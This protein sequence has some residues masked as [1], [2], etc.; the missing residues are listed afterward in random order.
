ML[1]WNPWALLVGMRNGAAAVK[2]S[3]VVPQKKLK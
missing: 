2:N 1:Y 3:M